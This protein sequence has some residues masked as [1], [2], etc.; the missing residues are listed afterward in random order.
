MKKFAALF[1]MIL[2]CALGVYA[3]HLVILHTNDTHSN[4]DSDSKGIGGILPRKAIMDSVRKVEK[5]V[6]AIDAGDMVQ[7]TLYFKYFKGDVEYPV[8]NMMDYDIRILGNH[9]FDNGLESLAHY[10]KDVKAERLSANYDFSGTP[11][12]G[13][14]KPYVI[15]K[16]GRKK[17]GFIGINIDPSSLIAKDSYAG[18]G[19]TDAIES[20]NRYAAILR[21][22]KKCDLVV[23]VTH[24][25][26]RAV[27][28][29]CSD[30]ELARK[31]R[32]IDI[33]IGGHSH[34][35]VDPSTPDRTPYWIKNLDGKPVL[36]AQ[37]GKYGRN[38][39]YI[40]ID[41]D[42]IADRKFDYEY[43]PV[44]D[45]FSPDAYSDE[46]REFLA[47]YKAKVDSVNSLVIARSAK[48][49]SNSD[50]RGAFANWAADFGLWYGRHIADSLRRAGRDIGA[51]DMAIMNVGGIR[52]PMMKG[53]VTEGQILSTFP[54][55][56]RMVIIAVKGSDIIKAMQA[57][58]LRGGEAISGNTRVVLDSD[59]NVIR[60]V[61][62]G[63][64][65]DP[66][67]TYNIST[68]DYVAQ[69]NDDLTPL[70]DHKE[71]WAGGEIMSVPL[72]AY[73]R[74]L[75]RLGLEIDPDPTPRFVE[76]VVMP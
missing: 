8:F 22:E 40:K 24:I 14:F 76:E 67:K 32:D 55:S 56:N 42:N 10:W 2:A 25:G 59:G 23:A 57:A 51:V 37:T 69:G 4:I 43:I 17:I 20:A 38:V 70:A 7:G 5:N 31:S 41:L 19:Y 65:M 27:P 9:E 53:D 62:D 47:P 29:K 13:L 73:V 50:H 26:Y 35:F 18:M 61:I 52:Q 6:I 49:M 39:G 48:D 63:D 64:E 45:R 75:T 30:V 34:T 74:M 36:V 3:D 60:V 54:F 58:A 21:K 72:L 16:V 68:I 28:G 46:I 71:L 1:L 66:E 15:R 11:A 33:I 44:T 12:E